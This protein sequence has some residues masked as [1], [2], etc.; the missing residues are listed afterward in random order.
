MAEKG[1]LALPIDRLD[2]GGSQGRLAM[3]ENKWDLVIRSASI[4]DGS[5]APPIEG[6]VAIKG[7]RIGAV[8]VVTGTSLREIDARGRALAPGFIDVHSHDDFALFISP[9]ME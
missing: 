1:R 2:D 3:P 4:Y 6:D 9:E 8:G 5:G 7:D